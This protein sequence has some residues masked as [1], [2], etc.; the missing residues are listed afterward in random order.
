MVIM[1]AHREQRFVGYL[2]ELVAREDRAALAALRRGLGKAPGEAAESHRYVVPFTS[3]LSARR[4][5]A[6]YQVAALFAWH[7]GSWQADSADPHST[8]LGASLERL[9]A[10]SMGSSVERRFVAL[11]NSHADDL[12]AHLRQVVGLLK[13]GDVPI[14]WARLLRDLQ[15]WDSED[16]Q[17]Q[18][19]WARAFWAGQPEPE[20]R[21][22]PSPS[23]ADAGTVASDTD[24]G[25]VP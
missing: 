4:E 25:D 17:V 10:R 14:D 12:D 7:Q 9:A 5:A 6:Y 23:G 20:G 16:R 11:L 21:T 2:R 13:A 3:D 15:H 22:A 8:N 1:P 19:A 24:N 18:R